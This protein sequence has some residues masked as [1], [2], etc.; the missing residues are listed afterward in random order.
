MP[1]GWIILHHRH[2]LFFTNPFTS[3][4]ILS[5]PSHPQVH[6]PIIPDFCCLRPD[7]F[8]VSYSLPSSHYPMFSGI[9]I[10]PNESDVSF[11]WHNYGGIHENCGVITRRR[12]TMRLQ[13]SSKGSGFWIGP[14]IALVEDQH[15]Y[16]D[17]T[18]STSIDELIVSPIWKSRWI[19][20]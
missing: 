4:F 8:N 5:L 11:D 19:T 20:N 17:I 10:R 7:I 15:F 14:S 3:T 2:S 6:P 12:T 18:W 16:S 9:C 1:I 13:G